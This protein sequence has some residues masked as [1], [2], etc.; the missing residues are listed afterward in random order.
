[1]RYTAMLGE[2]KMPWDCH[3]VTCELISLH[4]DHQIL[5]IFV[6]ITIVVAPKPVDVSKQVHF[7]S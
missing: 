6:G 3:H 2:L 5:E 4:W 7:Q 1:M